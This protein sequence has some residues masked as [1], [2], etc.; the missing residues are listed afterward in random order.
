MNKIIND[1]IGFSICDI[2]GLSIRGL[3][4]FFFNDNHFEKAI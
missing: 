1:L 4:I 3:N 2:I